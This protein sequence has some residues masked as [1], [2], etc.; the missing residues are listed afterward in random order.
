MK[1]TTKGQVTIP[2]ELRERLGFLPNT[3]VLFEAQG[4]SL[5][6]KKAVTEKRR[7][8]AWVARTCGTST[9]KWSTD[10]IMKMTRGED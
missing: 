4:T 9:S 3:E 7:M 2:Q 10:A 5:R 1:I 6:L 8:A